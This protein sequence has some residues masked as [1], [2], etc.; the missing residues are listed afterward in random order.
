MTDAAAPSTHTTVR[1]LVPDEPSASSVRELETVV[2]VTAKRPGAD[3][4][5]VLELA[6]VDGSE[7]PPWHPGAHVDLIVAG[8][9]ERQ[10]SLCGDPRDCTSYRLGVLRDN[11]GR[12]SSLHVHDVLAVGDEVRVRGP[13]NNF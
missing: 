12:G 3:G 10:Y 8:V 5:V 2:R 13:R 1:T 7:L 4:V 9:A 11:A 6:P